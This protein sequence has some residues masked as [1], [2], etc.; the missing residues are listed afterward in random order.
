MLG[1]AQ[2]ETQIKPSCCLYGRGIRRCSLFLPRRPQMPL[3]VYKDIENCY[4]FQK[5]K[6]IVHYFP[7]LSLC[8]CE[9]KFHINAIHSVLLHL[10]CPELK[11]LKSLAF[12]AN[13]DLL[14]ELL[15][16]P[17]VCPVGQ[18]QKQA[19]WAAFSACNLGTHKCFH[20]MHKRGLPILSFPLAQSPP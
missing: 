5:S 8:L 3:H 14:I 17:L 2:A 4:N 19:H 11:R 16:T 15:Y 18:V 10:H 6:C 7:T 1:Y 9:P 13:L 20:I 12:P